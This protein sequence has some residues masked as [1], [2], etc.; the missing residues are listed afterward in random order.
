A[1][2]RRRAARGRVR[3]EA[4]GGIGRDQRRV[5]GVRTRGHRPLHPRR[6]GRDARARA[7]E[8]AGR[9]RPAGRLRPQRLLAADGHPART[10][11][12]GDAL[13]VGQRAVDDLAVTAAVAGPMF[14]RDRRVLVTGATGFLGAH[15]TGL[16]VDLGAEVAIVVRDT[17]PATAVMTP[18]LD[19]VS[20]V[21]GDV[22]DQALL[23]RALGEYEVRTAFH[24][25]AQTQVEVANRN[26]VS[27]F[28][29]NIG[30]T[31][32]ML[33]ASRRSPLV[34]QVVLA[35]S[36]KAYGTQPRLP[37]SE[38]MPLLAVH[39]YDVSKACAD[40]ITVSYHR[41]WGVPVAI[42]RCGNFFGPGDTNWARLVPGTIRSLLRGERPVI[43]SDGTPVRDYLYVVDGAL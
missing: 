23:E 33:E 37:Y 39:P 38:D 22:R 35:S 14:W 26:A 7:P 20:V 43:R 24:L 8:Q 29:S 18:W 9:R 1:P 15:L 42:T 36:D 28:E 21:S 32:S 25:A 10:R 16:L 6:P 4:S 41:V 31:W 27:T 19:R 5:H 2:H 3:G 11:P 12:A 40:L 34:E 17:V 30:G 13:A